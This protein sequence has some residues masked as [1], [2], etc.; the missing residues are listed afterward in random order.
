MSIESLCMGRQGFLI[1]R[2]QRGNSSVI[3]KVDS[4]TWGII[5]G[6]AETDPEC[7][8]NYHFYCRLVELQNPNYVAEICWACSVIRTY[9]I[10][11]KCLVST[12]RKCKPRKV[13]SGPDGTILVL[14][15]KG[16]L[17]QLKWDSE[18]EKFHQEKTVQTSIKAPWCMTYMMENDTLIVTH[19]S[20]KCTCRRCL[21]KYGIS[22]LSA[23]PDTIQ[24]VKIRDGS[25]LWKVSGKVN[26]KEMFPSGICHDSMTRIY[27]ADS[28][29][30]RLIVLNT[31][32]GD[33]LDA[34]PTMELSGIVE[35]L[36]WSD[37][38]AQLIVLHNQNKVTS[39]KVTRQ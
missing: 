39:Y 6:Q 8:H 25:T 30:K 10:E 28:S 36:W 1:G 18:A 32:T 21:Y 4:H 11:R 29:N 35:G 14:D 19:A 33:V 7:G 22:H 9:N 26:D 24:A 34:V 37:T 2:M 23:S 12:Y 3:S 31:L 27:A 20:K 16:Q 38:S 13:C 5:S 15:N 17:L